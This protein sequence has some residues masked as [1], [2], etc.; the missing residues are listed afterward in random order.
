MINSKNKNKPPFNFSFPFYLKKPL[1]RLKA[2]IAEKLGSQL[3]Q[4][5]MVKQINIFN[6][7]L[8][9]HNQ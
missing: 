6:Q 2:W 7:L 5:Q 9:N 4:T 8:D 1:R 3:K